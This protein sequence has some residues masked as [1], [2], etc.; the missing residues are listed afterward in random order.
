MSQRSNGILLTACFTALAALT[1]GGQLGR[2]HGLVAWAGAAEGK[3]TAALVLPADEFSQKAAA[4]LNH[5]VRENFRRAP[6]FG[7]IEMRD[8][9]NKGATDSRL[10]ALE[11]GKKL[12]AEGKEQY[13]NLELDTAVEKLSKARDEFQKA[14]GQLRSGRDYLDTLLY[15]GAAYILSG[16]ADRGGEAFREVAMYD[17]RI[18]LDPKL[19]PPSMI[20]IFN[21]SRDAVSQG[22]VGNVQLKSNPPACEVFLNGVYKGIAPLSLMKIPE[23]S[24]FVEL[25]KDGYLPWGQR[26]EFFAAHEETVEAT[27]KESPNA[28][29]W[30]QNIKGLLGDLD[31]DEPKA[32]LVKFAQWLGV[33]RL[34]VVEAK[35][36]GDSVEAQAVLIQDAPAKKLAFRS[37]EFRIV[38]ANFLA[39]SDAFFTSL[40]NA[41][42][43]IPPE[44]GGGRKSDGPKVVT[45]SCNS[46]SDCAS[47]EVCD[48]SSNRCIPEA[49][50]GEHVYEKWWFWLALGGGAAVLAGAGVLIWY[51]TQPEQGA[52]EFTF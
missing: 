2:G 6:G 39:R 11:R 15:L 4:I 25:E 33:E 20:E 7:L 48:T 43:V 12:L 24:H 18:S 10:D 16:D 36:R 17:K 32:E 50:E 30:K 49:P 27:L 40:Y 52:I 1:F 21:Q 31:E 45:T 37:A 28:A 13:D 8:V 42:T 26:V 19:F 14:V 22:P 29:T 3:R 5:V 46:D 51:F 38:A 23:G 35:Q 44:E 47:G 41:S 34:V 9:L